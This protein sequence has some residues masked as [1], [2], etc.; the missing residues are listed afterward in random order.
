MQKT[1][2]IYKL[3]SHQVQFN[4]WDTAGQEKY[5][6]LTSMYFRDANVALLVYDVTNP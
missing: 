4:M 1:Q 6:S 2:T 5:R 3:G